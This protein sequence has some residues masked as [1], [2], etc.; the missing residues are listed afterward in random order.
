MA[1]LS[2]T[3]EMLVADRFSI[4]PW[5]AQEV[6]D[7][8]RQADPDIS[9]S[10]LELAILWDKMSD[11]SCAGWLIVD[12]YSVETFLARYADELRATSL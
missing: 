8:I 4:D 1:I 5:R 3:A 11:D 2:P 9:A 6:A 10:N 7:A 12:K